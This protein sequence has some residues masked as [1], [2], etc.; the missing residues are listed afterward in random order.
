[1]SCNNWSVSYLYGLVEGRHP[2]A[3]GAGMAI[4]VQTRKRDH[5]GSLCVRQTY[6]DQPDRTAPGSMRLPS[7]T[8]REV[9]RAWTA[10]LP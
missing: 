2:A 1:M 10:D 4:S 5:E 9:P 7:A 6:P 3:V 8:L